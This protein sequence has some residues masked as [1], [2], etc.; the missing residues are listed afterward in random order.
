MDLILVGLRNV[1]YDLTDVPFVA[2]VRGAGKALGRQNAY[3]F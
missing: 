1:A 2:M 3:Q